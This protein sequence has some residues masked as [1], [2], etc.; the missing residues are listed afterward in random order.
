MKDKGF[1]RE[2]SELF[3]KNFLDDWLNEPSLRS[4]WHSFFVYMI[5]VLVI[6]IIVNF[7]PIYD[8][9]SN[10]NNGFFAYRVLWSCFFTIGIFLLLVVTF[11]YYKFTIEK[12]NPVNFVSVLFFYIVTTM[13]FGLLYYE[14]FYASSTLFNYDSSRLT[15]IPEISRSAA[16]WANKFYFFLYSALVSVGGNFVYVQSNSV[17]VSIMNYV[18]TLYSFSLVSLLIAAYINQKTNKSA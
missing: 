15:W 8:I 10:I 12:G 1:L 7:L 13:L 9:L 6:S 17:I 3:L 2:I 11:N 14:V 18:Q 5:S 4:L 16:N